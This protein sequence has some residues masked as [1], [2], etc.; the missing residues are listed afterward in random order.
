MNTYESINT[1]GNWRIVKQLL[2]WPTARARDVGSVYVA[3]RLAEPEER[4]RS[5]DPGLFR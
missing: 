3:A 5:C 2:F 1:S 4:A